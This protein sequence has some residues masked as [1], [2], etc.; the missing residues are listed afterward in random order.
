MKPEIRI[1]GIDD[2][3]F[4]KT[5]KD[6]LVVGAVFRGAGFMDGVMSCRVTPDGDDATQKITD[7]ILRSKFRVQLRAV[8]LDGIA[9]GGFNVVDVKEIYQNTGIPVIVVMR[10]FPDLERIKQVLIRLGKEDKV[11]LMEKAG[12]IF[13]YDRIFFQMHGTSREET[14]KILKL[15]I[16][17]SYIPEPIRAAHLIGQ[18]IVFGE[19]KGRA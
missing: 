5:E 19:S 12:E 17:H 11:L 18:G 1:L 8:M 9:V 7:M 3:P 4:Y 15:S 6:V 16:T 10:T 2:S 13:S 14:E